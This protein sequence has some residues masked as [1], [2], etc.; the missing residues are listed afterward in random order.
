MKKLFSLFMSLFL[1]SAPS[2]PAPAAETQ[3]DI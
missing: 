2:V 3:N 1:A